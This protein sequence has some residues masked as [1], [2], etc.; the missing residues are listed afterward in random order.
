MYSWAFWCEFIDLVG[1]FWLLLFD[2]CHFVLRSVHTRRQVAATRCGDRS[3]NVNRSDD[4]LQQQGEATR[5]S[6]KSLRVYWRI[7]VKSLSPQQ[8]FVAATSRK[9][10]SQTEFV[11]LVAAT[12][13]CCSDK[14]FHKNSPVQ[15]KRFVAATCRRDM[16]LQ[17]VA[18]CVPTFMMN[19]TRVKQ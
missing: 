10:S 14:D 2:P 16:L 15:T 13:F 8:N 19:V 11:R 18:Q 7:F 6:D 5:R 3:L 1:F 12:K 4:Q 9:K 17:L